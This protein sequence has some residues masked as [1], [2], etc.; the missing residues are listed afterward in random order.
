M[1][2]RILEVALL[3]G[4][5]M[6]S[7]CAMNKS[8]SRNDTKEYYYIFEFAK[9]ADRDELIDALD[10]SLDYNV[11]NM[12]ANRPIPSA[13]IPDKPGRFQVVDLAA[14]MTGLMA[15]AAATNP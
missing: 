8:V 3:S 11:N 9:S 5:L 4:A 14:N 2:I 13:E 7:G 10:T 1:K 6:L 15:M 12:Q